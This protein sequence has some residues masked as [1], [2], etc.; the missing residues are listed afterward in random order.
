MAEMAQRG[1]RTYFHVS[2]DRPRLLRLLISYASNNWYFNKAKMEQD[3]MQL[4]T[5]H[6]PGHYGSV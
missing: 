6:T 1:D 5:E 4:I 3:L 2:P